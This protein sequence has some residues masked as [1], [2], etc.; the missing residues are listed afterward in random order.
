M[1]G[2]ADEKKKP[3]IISHLPA[4]FQRAHAPA[5]LVMV[6]MVISLRHKAI[7]GG[8]ATGSSQWRLGVGALIKRGPRRI[9]RDQLIG[10]VT[11]SD[12]LPFL[13]LC[14]NLR[15]LAAATSVSQ[16]RR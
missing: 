2:A 13:P 3:F 15:F 6:A 14:S 8:R 5:C 10:S 4:N 9:G 11:D 1:T 7:F 16:P 12:L